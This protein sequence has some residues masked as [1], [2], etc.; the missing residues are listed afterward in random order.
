MPGWTSGRTMSIMESYVRSTTVALAELATSIVSIS[1]SISCATRRR[2]QA[3]FSIEVHFSF[4]KT[5]ETNPTTCCCSLRSGA[6]PVKR[7]V[8]TPAPVHPSG[9]GKWRDT[10]YTSIRPA[11]VIRHKRR[12]DR[13][14]SRTQ[15]AEPERYLRI[16]RGLSRKILKKEAAR[17]GLPKPLPSAKFDCLRRS[18]IL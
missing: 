8:G 6:G 16:A 3:K 10:L 17:S 12:G 4:A 11:E 9:I 15:R 1:G 2:R 13:L 14:G 18:K 7:G 5:D